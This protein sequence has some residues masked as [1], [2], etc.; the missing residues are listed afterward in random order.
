AKYLFFQNRRAKEKRLKEAEIEKLRINS[1]SLPLSSNAFPS[2][3][4]SLVGLVKVD[5]SDCAT[6]SQSSLIKH[7]S[8]FGTGLSQLDL[9]NPCPLPRSSP[10]PSS[11]MS[12]AESLFGKP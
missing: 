6:S 2:V 3:I 1:R 10:S 5:S 4:P 7:L 12:I 9:G 8:L 11:S